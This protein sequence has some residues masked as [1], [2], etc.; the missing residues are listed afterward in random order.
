[1]KKNTYN[2]I[3]H[4]FEAGT[5]Y[6]AGFIGLGPAVEFVQQLGFEAIHAHEQDLL[7]YATQRLLPIE[8]L[9]II[10][11]AQEKSAVIS[12][13]HRRIR[14]ANFTGAFVSGSAADRRHS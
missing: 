2:V 14:S 7:Q 12:L 8:G 1:M 4:K 9:R 11:T 5:P 10:G 13:L 3:P 6:I